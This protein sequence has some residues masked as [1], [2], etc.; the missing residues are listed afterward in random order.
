MYHRAVDLNRFLGERTPRWT[1]LEGLLE[2][3]ERGGLHTLPVAE[4]QRFAALYRTVSGDLMVARTRTANAEV[5]DYLNDLVARAYVQV[6]RSPRLRLGCLLHM[7]SNQH[8]LHMLL[9]MTIQMHI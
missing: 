3:V 5:V 6:Y 2:R 9:H 8:T 7:C 1:E 4:A